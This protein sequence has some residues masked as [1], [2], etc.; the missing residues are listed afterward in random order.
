[1]FSRVIKLN[2]SFLFGLNISLS[3]SKWKPSSEF[4]RRNFD[5]DQQNKRKLSAVHMA[6]KVSLLFWQ[7]KF[8]S[9]ALLSLTI[10]STW[11]SVTKHSSITI[12]SLEV[13]IVCKSW[14]HLVLRFIWKMMLVVMLLKSLMNLVKNLF[15]DIWL[16]P[17]AAFN[18]PSKVF[19]TELWFSLAAWDVIY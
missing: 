19:K 8:G 15:S 11:C 10:W 7:P 5:L 17:K 3:W 9:D 6:A 1:M 12:F 14:F 2:L 16:W 4:K 13:F 18:S